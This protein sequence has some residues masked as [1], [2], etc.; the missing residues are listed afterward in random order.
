MN[1]ADF[2]AAMSTVEADHRFV[3]EKVCA[4]K[5]AVS[6]LMGMGDK[7]ARAVFGQLRQLLE[8]FADEFGA[9]A[10]EEEQTLFPLIEEQL[11][12]GAQ[13]VARL[14]Q[15]H[16][17]IRCK[18]QEFADC[19]EVASELEDDVPDAVLADLLAY[20]WELW[21]LLDTHAHTETKALREAAA[22]YLRT[23]MDSMILA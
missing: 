6:C 19:L 16:E 4:L 2:L 10:A 15:D 13:V 8:F 7:P 12:D 23:S 11:P 1:V 21:E 14:R 18:R 5:D 22:H 3:F 9:H 17:T 20:G